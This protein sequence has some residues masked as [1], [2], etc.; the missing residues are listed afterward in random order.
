MGTIVKRGDSYRAVVRK[1]GYPTETKTFDKKALAKAWI[2]ETEQAIATKELRSRG[3]NIGK[4]VN[5]YI[6]EV[7]PMIKL[8]TDSE[9]SFKQIAKMTA[10]LYLDDLTMQSLLDMKKEFCPNAG[11]ASFNRYLTSI[12]TVLSTAEAMWDVNIPWVEFRKAK[13]SLLTVR[14]IASG[15]RRTRRLQP[16]ELESLRENICTTLP[17]SDIVDLALASCMRSGELTRVRWDDLDRAKRTI[18][19]RDRKHPTEK[20]GN[21]QTIPLLGESMSIIERQPKTEDCIF[22][23]KSDSVEAAFRRAVK[24]AGIVDLSFHDLRHEGISRLFEQ[25]YALQEVAIVSGH[26]SW[27]S[28]KI[29]T[30]LKPESLHRD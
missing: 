29:Y 23:Y 10:R 8:G 15:G 6:T 20:V 21:H 25:G 19:I 2:T 18:L 5:K 14:A 9:K 13:K 12:S 28:L 11:P 3:V 17:L 4:L 7:G 22:P 16:G 27:N 1:V 26:R 30:N 24:A